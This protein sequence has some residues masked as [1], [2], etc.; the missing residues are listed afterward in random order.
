MQEMGKRITLAIFKLIFFFKFL[1]YLLSKSAFLEVDDEVF[2]LFVRFMV[3]LLS[4]SS[5]ARHED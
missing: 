3:F 1:V 2:Y 4:T 5:K